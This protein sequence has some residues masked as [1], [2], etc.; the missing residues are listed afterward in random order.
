MDFKEIAREI[1]EGSAVLLKNEGSLLPLKP[2]DTVAFFGRAQVETLLSGNGSGAANVSEPQSILAECEKAGL[3]PSKGLK[4]FYV[5][6]SEEL[7]AG[8]PA[9]F[10][11][12]Q[13]THMVN[14]G[15]MYEF[16]GKYNP[17][18]EEFSVPKELISESAEETDT[19][20]LIIGRASGGEECDRHFDG[21]YTLSKEEEELISS[22]CSAFP[23]VAVILNI[24]GL[25]DLSFTEKYGSIKSLLFLGIPGE[26]GP[27]ALARILTGEVNPSGK[28][29][30]TIA[31]RPEDYPY[32]EDFSWDKDHPEKIKTYEDYGISPKENGRRKFSKSPVTVY[33][34][35]IYLGYR[36]F[37]SFGVEPLFPFGFGLSY[38]DFSIRVLGVQKTGGGFSVTATVKNIGG[39]AGREVLQVYVSTHKT[40][41][42]RPKKELKA[43]SKTR[44]LSPGE[45]ETVNLFIPACELACFREDLACKV[46]ERGTYT[47]LVG[48]SSE[49]LK[50]A[51]NILVAEDIVTEKCENRLSP[52]YCGKLDFLS[53]KDESDAPGAPAIIEL[54]DGDVDRFAVPAAQNLD[55][56]F[57]KFSLEELA[58]LCVGYGPGTPFAALRETADPNTIFTESGEPV[59][60]NSHPS[61]M[62]GYVSPAIESKGIYSVYY[63][64]GP[65]GVG[66]TAWPSEMLIACSFDRDL[67][68]KFG[69]AVGEQCEQLK[70]D[71]WLAPAMNLHRHPLGGRN[72]EYFSE[73]PYLTGALACAVSRGVEENHPVQVCAKH[74]AVNEQ[75]TYRRGST[76]LN[77]DAV[78]S[79][80]T[81]RAARELY[82]KPF[83]MLVKAGLCHCVMT[84]FNKINGEFAGGNSDLC[85]GILR[86]EWGFDGVVVTDWGDMDT[87][88]YG[89]DAVKAG[90]DVVMP[91]GPPVIAE[92]LDGEKEGRVDREALEKAVSHLLGFISRFGRYRP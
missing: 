72:F 8:K 91:G 63:K 48:N 35:N 13:L 78:D 15:L 6:K 17:P 9:G 42:E 58:A 5:R 18:S 75:E 46:I 49:S 25:I 86:D 3:I 34:E 83:E 82:L 12:S 65:A 14:S 64:D 74:F 88:V 77:Y 23:K 1:V 11:L 87:V 16:F 4:E 79:I 29:S 2:G 55:V 71:V 30:V 32:W 10:D 38:T 45:E 36:Y 22:V 84:A 24:N 50:P 57:E 90:N 81:E 62:N 54:T 19:A 59:T 61:G 40:E 27:A 68:E 21:D 80:L 41:S 51:A 66:Q 89:A 52:A 37:S 44:K 69:D 7:S 20:V 70:V 33:R 26:E 85:T 73:D 67:C 76:K 56:N 28:L 53:I 43:F 60:T 31:K 92:I 39:C 47:I